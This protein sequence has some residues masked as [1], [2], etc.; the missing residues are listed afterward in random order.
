[1]GTYPGGLVEEYGHGR[2]GQV[3]G[4]VMLTVPLAVITTARGTSFDVM[5]KMHVLG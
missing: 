2:D 1:V 3:R 5:L 4:F